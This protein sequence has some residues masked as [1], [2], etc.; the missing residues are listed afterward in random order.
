[1]S[2]K[3]VSLVR[4]RTCG[5]H[6]F[7]SPPHRGVECPTCDAALLA[8][9]A[10]TTV[11]SRAGARSTTGA[12]RFGTTG[13]VTASVVAGNLFGACLASDVYGGPPDEPDIGG[14]DVINDG[15]TDDDIIDVD[16]T[17]VDETDDSD[18]DE[19]TAPTEETTASGT[20]A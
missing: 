8:G 19:D 12:R 20:D 7:E 14:G 1:M 15:M 18:A 9:A 10:P 16:E 13:W 17:D 11:T 4:C 5:T 2:P 6:C 3:P